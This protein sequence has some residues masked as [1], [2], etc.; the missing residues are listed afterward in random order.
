MEDKKNLF[1]DIEK[2]IMNDEKPSDYL[3]ELI[4]EEIF[5]TTYPFTML[6]DLLEVQQNKKYH[7]EGNVFNHTLL[8]VDEAAKRRNDSKNPRVF[9]WAALLHD[10]GKK[11]ATKIKKD[12]IT[13][14]NHEKFGKEMVQDFLSEFTKDENFIH[15]VAVMVRWHMECLFIVKN[16]P[17]ANIEDMLKEVSL[18]EISLLSTCDRFGRGNMTCEKIEDEEKSITLFRNICERANKKLL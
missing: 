6:S 1:Y 8:V 4:K 9:M 13:S 12:K 14:Y 7:P 11:P 15:D 18:D 16:L 10:I 17:F 3:K 2:H 5:K